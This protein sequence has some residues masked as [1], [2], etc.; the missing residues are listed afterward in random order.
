MVRAKPRRRKFS[1]KR[2][3]DGDEEF[4]WLISLSDLMI[5]LFIFFVVMFAFS[6]SKLKQTDVQRILASLRNEKLPPT[7]VEV[8]E[9]SLQEWI[10]TK[11][12]NEQIQVR[13]EGDDLLIEIKDKLLFSSGSHVPHPAGKQIL[14]LMARTISS[15]PEPYK[16]GIEGHTDDSPIHTTTIEDNWEL[17]SKRSLSVLHVMDLAPVLLKRTVLMSFAEMKPLVPNRTP[18]GHAIAENQGKNRRV[19]IRIFL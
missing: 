5:L 7:P 8:I 13:K 18:Q 11:K 16:V 17:A 1:Q 2:R 14:Q 3:P 15:V 19:T 10:Q 12:L 4:L 9:N 6:H